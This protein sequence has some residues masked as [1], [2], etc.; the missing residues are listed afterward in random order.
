MGGQ[1][2]AGGVQRYPLDVRAER[3]AAYLR[4]IAAILALVGG[5][6]LLALPYIVPRVLAVVGILFAAAFLRRAAR[7]RG[8]AEHSYLEIGPAGLSICEGDRVERVPFSEILS[9]SVDDDRLSVVI[10][11]RNK[12]A[13]E[14]EPRYRGLNLQKLATAI[15]T[16]FVS[17]RPPPAQPT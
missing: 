13:L 17:S 1:D 11:R 16:G 14:I 12:P 5:A 6:W 3:E 15:H 2:V 7:A 9:V 4:M 10:A 8:A